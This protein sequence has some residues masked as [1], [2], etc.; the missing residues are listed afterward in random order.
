MDSLK[1]KTKNAS[2]VGEQPTERRQE[3]GCQFLRVMLK[4]KMVVAIQV[5]S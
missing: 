2:N 4:S 1:K 5:L 3:N